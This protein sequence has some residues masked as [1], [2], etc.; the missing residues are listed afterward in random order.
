MLLERLQTV[1]TIVGVLC[2]L[3]GLATSSGCAVFPKGP[4]EAAWILHPLLLLLGVAAGVVTHLRTRDIDRKRWRIVQDTTLTKGEVEYAHREAES[5][6]RISSTVFLG[7]PL[8]LGFWMAYQFRSEDR[9]TAADLL[10]MTPLLGYLLGYFIGQLKIR[11]DPPD[12]E[13]R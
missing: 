11:E 3:L 12:A 1:V 6:R 4:P 7:A 13:S 5:A 10:V 8:A 9:R 2:A